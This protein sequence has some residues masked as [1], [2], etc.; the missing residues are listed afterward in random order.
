MKS[1]ISEYTEKEFLEF[2]KDIYTNNKKKFPTEESHIQ[3]VLEFKKL[4]EHPNGSDLLYYPNE[5]REDSPA[6]VVK[7]VKEWR[8]SKGLPG[9]K[10]G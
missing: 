6:G 2:V 5:N 4:T 7:E 8:A 3:A 1:K 9:F 10:A